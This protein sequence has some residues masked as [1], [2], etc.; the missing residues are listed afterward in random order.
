MIGHRLMGTSLTVDGRHRGR[1]SASRSARGALRSCRASSAGDA[2]WPRPRGSNLMLA[3]HGSVA[4][5]LSRGCARGRRAR[6]QNAREIGQA[7]TLMYALAHAS[8]THYLLRK[9]RD[10]KTHS[11]MKSSRWRTKKAPRLEGV[12]ND[13]RGCAFGADRQSRRGSPD[14]TSGMQ[15][16]GQPEQHY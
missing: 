7:A 1:P 12:R 9:L 14:D 2:I 10:S 11:S 8:W 5:W 15:H 6:A 13:G 3:V 4:A 16:F